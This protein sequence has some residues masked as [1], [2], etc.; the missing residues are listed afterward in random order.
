MFIYMGLEMGL[1]ARTRMTIREDNVTVATTNYL[2]AKRKIIGVVTVIRCRNAQA[3][4][5]LRSKPEN[6]RKCRFAQSS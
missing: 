5:Y 6:H 4:I 3:W 1:S 2:N